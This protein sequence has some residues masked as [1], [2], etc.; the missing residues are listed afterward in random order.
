MATS[1]KR[2]LEQSKRF[3]S[4]IVTSILKAGP[5]YEAEAYHQNYYET[6]RDHYKTYRKGSG[7]EQ[8]LK[9]WW[10]ESPITESTPLEFEKPSRD[11]LKRSL[12]SMQY[13]VTQENGTE[14]PFRNEFWNHKGEGIYVDVVSNEPLFS[15]T[16]KYDS[17]TGWPSYYEPVSTLNVVEQQDRSFGMIRREVLCARCG[18]HLGHVFDDGPPPTGKRY[19]INGMALKFVPEGQL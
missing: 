3:D 8:F 2:A 14:Y 10:E 6:S 7:R 16:D 19:C 4:P 9:E 17:G 11:E 13:H 1:S 12:T 15:S 18:S 5:F